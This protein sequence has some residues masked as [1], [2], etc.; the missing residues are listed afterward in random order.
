MH[1]GNFYIYINTFSIT[2]RG[3][4]GSKRKN[5]VNMGNLR[6]EDNLDKKSKST[7][8]TFLVYILNS[9]KIINIL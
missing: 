6:G 4:T 7:S 5:L 2:T 9:M 3:K 1:I 8:K